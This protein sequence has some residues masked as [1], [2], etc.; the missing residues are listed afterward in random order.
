MIKP[1]ITVFTEQEWEDG[2]EPYER[3]FETHGEDKALVDSIPIEYVWTLVDGDEGEPSI[4]NGMA[5]VN[6]IGYY[7]SKM[8]HNPNDLII[9]PDDDDNEIPI[10]YLNEQE[11]V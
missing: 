6:R 10:V 1:A 2:Y 8:P 5:Y 3:L 9:V 11:D 4:T 7:I